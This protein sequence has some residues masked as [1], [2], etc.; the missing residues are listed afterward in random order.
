M[1]L[2]KPLGKNVKVKQSRYKPELAY[3]VDRGVALSFHD[4]GAR[5]G[6]V[7]STTAR[8]LYTWER[9]GTHCTGGSVGPR[10]GLDMCEKSR[11]H[12]DSI[13]GPSSP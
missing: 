12:R 9:P 2:Y 3:R 10:A 13:P 5:R 11:P 4:L 8:P 7:V 6:W 1:T